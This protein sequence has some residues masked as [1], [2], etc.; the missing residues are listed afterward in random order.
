MINEGCC[1]Q[2]PEVFF[3]IRQA[4]LMKLLKCSLITGLPRIPTFF[5]SLVLCVCVCVYCQHWCDELCF[6]GVGSAAPC[7][8]PHLSISSTW[9]SLLQLSS[10]WFTHRGRARVWCV[11]LVQAFRPSAVHSSNT[12]IPLNWT[13]TAARMIC[14]YWS[15]IINLIVWQ[16]GSSVSCYMNA[17]CKNDSS[18]PS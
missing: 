7:S 13:H 17:P 6:W 8:Q 12:F 10:L 11:P 3:L 16:D 5:P 9:L 15:F 18:K 4:I 14:Q 2:K 1:P